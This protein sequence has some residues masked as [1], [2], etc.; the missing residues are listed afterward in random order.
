MEKHQGEMG[1]KKLSR[2]DILKAGK[3]DL[4]VTHSSMRQRLEF[5][6]VR[7]KTPAGT[8]PYLKVE[9]WVDSSELLRLAAELDLPIAAPSG[10]F[11]APG[12]KASDYVGL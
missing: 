8:V 7:E 4:P 2:A 12:K 5:V 9:R 10:R 6:V 1:E 3:A 11:F